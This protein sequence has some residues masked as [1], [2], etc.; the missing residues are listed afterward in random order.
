MSARAIHLT[1]ARLERGFFRIAAKVQDNTILVAH[2]YP[3]QASRL[4]N[5]GFAGSVSASN[6][7]VGAI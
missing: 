1:G 7:E 2:G 5:S 3:A 6:W 4:A